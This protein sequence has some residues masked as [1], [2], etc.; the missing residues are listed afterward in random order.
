MKR[1][2]IT[3]AFLPLLACCGKDKSIDNTADKVFGLAA[4]QLELLDTYLS[5]GEMP[6][7][8]ENGRLATRN[9]EWWC[10][11]FYPGSLCLTAIYTGDEEVAVLADKY[12]HCL[13]SLLNYPISHDVGFMLNCSFGNHLLLRGDASDSLIL[14]KGATALAGRFSPVTGTTRSWDHGK[15]KWPVIIDNMMNLELLMRFGTEEERQ[16]AISH[17]NKTIQNHFR[18]DYT[19]WHVL[20]YDPETGEV[21]SKQTHQGLSDDS[22][23]ARGQAWGLYG[24]TMMAEQC[25]EKGYKDAS[26]RYLKQAKHIAQMLLSRL[27]SDGIPVW[28]LDAPATDPRDA[29]A[30]AI[31]ASA[32]IELSK[33]T[34]GCFSHRCLKMA[35]TQLQ[36]LASDEYLSK[37]D[38]NFG[39]LIKHCV[40]NLPGNSEVDVPLT[41]ADYYFLEALIRHKNL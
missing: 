14:R 41:Y 2:L 19:T 31:M 32:F 17:A 12:T 10:S 34:C 9:I 6:R 20:D 25:A 1:A 23:W 30:A 16:M 5:D 26:G 13:D 38:E 21:L 11:G 39:F 33:L 27:P 8:V 18:P 35:E 3:L 29:S 36:T 40:G 24:F 4:H 7:S 28:D 15:W 37:E 22:A